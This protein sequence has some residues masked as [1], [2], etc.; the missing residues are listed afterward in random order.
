MEVVVVG[1]GYVGLVT[2]SVLSYIGH[3]VT[4]VDVDEAKI[5]GLQEGCSPIFE[6][7]LEEMIR[8]GF[9]NHRLIFATDYEAGSSADV[10]FITVSTPSM[11]GGSVDLSYVKSASIEIGL[12]LG[13]AR[14]QISGS[15]LTV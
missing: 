9:D 11:A 10:I 1:A 8:V 4:C 2:G 14:V 5:A 3:S 6:P 7:G 12:H 13:A 15:K